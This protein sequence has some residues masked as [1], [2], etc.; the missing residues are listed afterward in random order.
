[1]EMTETAL[2]LNNAT[3]HS[4]VLL[5]EIGRGTSTFDGLSLAWAV[6]HAIALEIGALTLFATHYFELTALPESLPD[7][8]NVHLSAREYGDDI[9]FMY[10]VNEGP[11]SQSYGLQ[12]AR[13]AGVPDS[14]IATARDKLRQL[15]EAEVRAE[16]N[17]APLQSDLFLNG[18]PDELREML[19]DL[20]VDALSPREALEILYKLHQK[21][22]D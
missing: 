18:E 2:I 8:R 9:I 11:A 15:E 21:A 4:L 12:V 1:V 5:D 13:L 6:A 3:R 17:G 16:T 20:D 10:S 14:V 7:T 22:G 19:K